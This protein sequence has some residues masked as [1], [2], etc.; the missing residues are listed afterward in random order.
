MSL[1]NKWKMQKSNP[2]EDERKLDLVFCMRARES[3]RELQGGSRRK[4]QRSCKELQRASSG[5]ITEHAFLHPTDDFSAFFLCFSA[6]SS[7]SAFLEGLASEVSYSNADKYP[8]QCK[9]NTEQAFLHNINNFSAFFLV[10]QILLIYRKRHI[11]VCTPCKALALKKALLLLFLC[12]YKHGFAI[13]EIP[14][15]NQ[16]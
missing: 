4:L 13:W 2:W 16:I 6:F 14:F 10:C 7:F 8:Q 9:I 3:N 12:Y 11:F 15:K 5:T 1:K